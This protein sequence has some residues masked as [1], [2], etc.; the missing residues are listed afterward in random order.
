MLLWYNYNFCKTHKNSKLDKIITYAHLIKHVCV[1]VDAKVVWSVL[2]K[3]NIKHSNIN[4]LKK[5]V[6]VRK[7]KTW[8]SL[9][10]AAQVWHIWKI[11]FCCIFEFVGRLYS[12]F[13]GKTYTK[14]QCSSKYFLNGLPHNFCIFISLNA[15]LSKR[16]FFQFY[17]D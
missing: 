13:I 1:Y 2:G 10:G 6:L 3:K 11:N 8:W 5:S 15:F 16:I 7:L 17:G 9:K 4:V 12:T 14:K